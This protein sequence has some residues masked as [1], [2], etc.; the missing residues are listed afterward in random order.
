MVSNI[1]TNLPVNGIA[2][3]RHLRT[4]NSQGQLNE[5]AWYCTQSFMLF[6]QSSGIHFIF[7]FCKKQKEKLNKAP[8]DTP[9]KVCYKTIAKTTNLCCLS[10]EIYVCVDIY[11]QT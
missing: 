2:R 1:Y 6:K 7:F 11:L 4:G 3:P 8:T 9:L 10:K 5:E